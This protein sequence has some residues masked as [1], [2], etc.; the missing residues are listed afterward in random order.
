MNLAD[1]ARVAFGLC[2]YAYFLFLSA[3][4][5]AFS[6]N[7]QSYIVRSPPAQAFPEAAALVSYIFPKTVRANSGHSKKG[8]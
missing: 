3:Y 7:A 8:A 4:L 2:V 1:T 5:F 6:T